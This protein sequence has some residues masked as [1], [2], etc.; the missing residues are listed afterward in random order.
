[1]SNMKTMNSTPLDSPENIKSKERKYNSPQEI[2][3][4]IH[5]NYEKQNAFR[6][7]TEP[8]QKI[9][10]FK[11]NNKV[12]SMASNDHNSIESFAREC[13]RRHRK[14]GIFSKKKTLK[15][16]LVHTKKPLKKPMI[17]TISDAL[18]I[19]ESVACFK[20]IQ[21]YMGDRCASPTSSASS[22][23][24]S[25][26]EQSS[27]HERERLLINLINTCVTL[28]PLRDEVLVQIA[29]QVTQNPS[30]E[31]E[32]RGLE[33][34]CSLF[35]YFTASNKLAMHLQAFLTSHRNP[36][37][38]CVRRKFEQQLHRSKNT[39]SHLFC[40]KPH[41]IEEVIRVL[42]CVRTKH[43]GVFGETLADAVCT[44]NC[45]DVDKHLPWPVVLLT[46]A[47]LEPRHEDREGVFRCVGDMDDVHKLKM[48]L[49][50]ISPQDIDFNSLIGRSCNSIVKRKKLTDDH[51]IHVIASTLK[52]YFRE[53]RESIIPT[54]LYMEALDCAHD[55][56]R[57]CLF[58][59]KL[60]P[61]NRST[62]IY[63][64]KFLQI[65]SKPEH[66]RHTKMDDANLSMVWAPNI[67]RGP[68]EGPVSVKS[69]MNSATLYERTRAEM[70]LV[71]TLIQQFETS[72][73][74]I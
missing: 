36:F 14:G 15:S 12:I 49:D 51:D 30:I 34:M 47:I 24:Y 57:A 62:L 6:T 29:R 16:M 53:L 55:P 70:S 60:N 2:I 4:D 5:L 3:S 40:R 38:A 35:W 63:L 50:T 26:F 19:K 37:T 72:N 42:K 71:R 8:V 43:V 45:D 52:L 32:R 13:V 31:S 61:L 64:I 41:S 74:I 67:L 58:V 10:D 7:N 56:K 46:K 11:Q 39:H 33:L 68:P 66:V 20:M 23:K 73:S 59:N 28:V 17:S 22:L 44:T 69:M 18:L 27:L 48:K 21:I 54:D 25:P 1:M 65:F 9:K